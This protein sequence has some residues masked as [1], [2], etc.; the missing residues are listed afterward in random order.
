MRLAKVR[1][2]TTTDGRVTK[3]MTNISTMIYYFICWFVIVAATALIIC[4]VIIGLP[5][6]T[7]G[8]LDYLI[9]SF[10]LVGMWLYLGI[11]LLNTTTRLMSSETNNQNKD[12][13]T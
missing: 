12:V 9:T 4:H 10:V 3:N 6:I 1:I 8:Q 7:N 13:V 11:T 5:K 2:E